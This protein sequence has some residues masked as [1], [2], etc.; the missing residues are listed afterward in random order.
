MGVVAQSIA[1]KYK[2]KNEWLGAGQGPQ[3][4]DSLITT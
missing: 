3:A 1:R 2:G 4:W